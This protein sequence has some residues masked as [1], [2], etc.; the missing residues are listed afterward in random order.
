[1][2]MHSSQCRCR[3]AP[4]LL[5][6]TRLLHGH[7]L[8]K[9]CLL[10]LLV[11]MLRRAKS[12]RDLRGVAHTLLLLLLLWLLLLTSS[13]SSCQPRPQGRWGTDTTST[14][15]SSSSSSSHASTCPNSACPRELHA[16]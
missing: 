10:L 4:L 13:T 15:T 14:T 6:R 1:M 12:C 11:P 7:T 2:R 16:P 5:L 3:C 9:G 8:C